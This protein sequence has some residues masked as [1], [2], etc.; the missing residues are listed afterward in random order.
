M[1]SG[2]MVKVTLSQSELEIDG[3]NV[4]LQEL[5]DIKGKSKW[6]VKTIFYNGVIA[7]VS[8]NSKKQDKIQL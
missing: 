2:V 1:G 8:H 3:K 7:K 5:A 4:I 6:T